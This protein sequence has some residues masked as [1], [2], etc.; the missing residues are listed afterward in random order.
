MTNSKSF[1]GLLSDLPLASEFNIQ[2]PRKPV[3]CGSRELTRPLSKV[4]FSSAQVE[5]V[6]GEKRIGKVVVGV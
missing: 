1:I 3:R 4:P 5:A 2:L 6:G